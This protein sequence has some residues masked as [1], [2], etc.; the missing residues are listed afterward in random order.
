LSSRRRVATYLFVAAVPCAW[1]AVGALE[2]PTSA[3][4]WKL[5]TDLAILSTTFSVLFSLMPHLSVKRPPNLMDRVFGPAYRRAEVRS[6][7]ALQLIPPIV[8]SISV[9]QEIAAF[10]PLDIQRGCQLALVICLTI[11]FL[12]HTRLPPARGESDATT[13]RQ[14][15]S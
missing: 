1:I 3:D 4:F 9:L 13:A 10:T 2:L 7:F 6:A 14:V 5:L 8:G 11:A 15:L 12:Q